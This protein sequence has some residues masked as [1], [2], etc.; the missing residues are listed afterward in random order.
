MA[1]GVPVKVM[2]VAVLG[3]ILVFVA[4]ILATVGAGL[5]FTVAILTSFTH[6][7]VPVTV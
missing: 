7:A 3:Q 1:P 2:V 5:I 4:T 6:G